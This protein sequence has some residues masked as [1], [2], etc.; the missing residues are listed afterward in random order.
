MGPKKLHVWLKEDSLSTGTVDNSHKAN[1]HKPM[2]IIT[3]DPWHSKCTKGMLK[4][5]RNTADIPVIGQP[6]DAAAI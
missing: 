6:G 2:H 5:G 1:N 4:W 3:H